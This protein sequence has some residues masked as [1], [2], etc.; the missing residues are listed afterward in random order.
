MNLSNT[1]WILHWIANRNSGG[2]GEPPTPTK[3]APPDNFISFYCANNSEFDYWVYQIDFSNIRNFESMFQSLG[4]EITY[5]DIELISMMATN[6]KNCFFGSNYID[7][8][9]LPED[10]DTSGCANFGGCFQNCYKLERIINLDKID[11]SS[12]TNLHYFVKNCTNL[13]DETLAVLCDKL[14]SAT[15]LQTKTLNDIGLT[16]SQA[17]KC[18]A[19]PIW[20]TLVN[21]GWTTGY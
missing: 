16:N 8:V 2:T 9:V 18:T 14:Q 17:T 15:E 4:E 7:T 20:S 13:Y 6:M 19:F 1:P 5:V 12:A 10:I 11:F 3:F 21:L